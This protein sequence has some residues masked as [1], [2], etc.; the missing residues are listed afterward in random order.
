PVPYEIMEAMV[1]CFGKPF[2]YKD[3][4][5]TFFLMQGVPRPLVDKCRNEPKFVWARIP[6]TELSQTEDGRLL[7]RKVLTALC[8][9]CKVPDT[10]V[11]DWD[12]AVD[13]LR[14]VKTLAAQH[15]LAA[16]E[17]G[18]LSQ[19]R[20]VKQWTASRWFGTEPPRSK[21]SSRPSPV[22]SRIQTG[23]RRDTRCR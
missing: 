13:A 7:Q 16:K 9:L 10:D 6:L 8:Q 12:G 3:G 15:D 20:L 21:S 1:Q 19:T 4:V 5:A 18:Q 23:R 14:Q 22:P 2:R 11:P 17:E